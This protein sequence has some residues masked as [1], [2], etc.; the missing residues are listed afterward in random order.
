[1]TID[2]NLTDG[3]EVSS[4]DDLEVKVV[5][6]NSSLECPIC[7]TLAVPRQ[8]PTLSDFTNAALDHL[9]DVH[10]ETRPGSTAAVVAAR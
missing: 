9:A 3:L 1:M 2:V 5:E 10:G 7:G 8:A 6:G 4:F